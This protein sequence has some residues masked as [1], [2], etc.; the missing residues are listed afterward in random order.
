MGFTVFTGV[1]VG[2]GAAAGVV[3]LAGSAVGFCGALGELG[4]LAGFHMFGLSSSKVWIA[5]ERRSQQNQFPGGDSFNKAFRWPN[6]CRTANHWHQASVQA[7]ANRF[8]T[9]PNEFQECAKAVA[10]R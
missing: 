3:D 8:C 2:A 7:L 4:A 5:R 1:E 9:Y 10:N 6:C